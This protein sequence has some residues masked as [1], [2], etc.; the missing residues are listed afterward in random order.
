M[1]RVK[2]SPSGKPSYAELQKQIAMLQTQAEQARQQE[3]A[4]V[5]ARIQEAIKVYELSPGDLFP[6]ARSP[7]AKPSKAGDGVKAA[8]KYRDPA[9]GKTWT[10]N[11]KRPG[12]FVAAIESG[13]SPE[14]LAA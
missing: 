7:R 1:A 12:W 2:T 3:V 4:E 8:A 11:G 6:S 10:G 14:S 13:A 9:S 5:I